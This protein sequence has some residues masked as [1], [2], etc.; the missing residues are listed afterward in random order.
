MF[1]EASVP[2]R[3]NLFGNPLDI[4]GGLVMSSSVAL[5]AKVSARL[6][7][8]LVFAVGGQ[9][10][11]V[12]EA[13]DLISR[14]D[15]FDFLRALVRSM[16]AVPNCRIEAITD[17]PIRSGLAGS[18]AFMVAASACLLTL[19]GKPAS[20]DEILLAAH[21]SEVEYLG[22]FCGWNDFY[23]CILGGAHAMTYRAPVDGFP[24]VRSLALPDGEVSFAIALTGSMHVS[25]SVNRSLWD[26][27]REGD[28][29]VRGEYAKL[30]E[31]GA[32]AREA[33]D[34]GDWARFGRL[35]HE[36]F[37]CQ[38]RLA[39]AN[40][41]EHR[42]VQGAMAHGAFGAKLSGAGHCGSIVVLARNGD[43]ERIHRAL[44]PLGVQRY[45]K[46]EPAVGLV[47]RGSD[48]RDP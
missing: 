8:E 31:L 42:L 22:N 24:N 20:R 18:A 34:A 6:S 43:H 3:V 38:Y 21:R 40:E 17:I 15:R 29:V 47:V 26:R 48:A 12:R 10:F 16:D 4:Y 9:E 36:N 27:W 33:F 19:A 25:G 30:A 35:M 11:A 32:A 44:E 45:L 46:V 41:I 1:V 37:M 28:A 7:D 13:G 23:A 5:R 14:N 2:G 39:A